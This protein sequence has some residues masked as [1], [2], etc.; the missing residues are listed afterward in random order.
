MMKLVFVTNQWDSQVSV[1]KQRAFVQRPDTDEERHVIPFEIARQVLPVTTTPCVFVLL[2]ELQGDFP[3]ENID[4]IKQ[5]VQ[6][7]FS[8]TQEPSE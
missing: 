6:R 1:P 5:A 4:R 8:E 2:D 7:E 3:L